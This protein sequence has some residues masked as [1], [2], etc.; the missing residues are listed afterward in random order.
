MNIRS[1]LSVVVVAV[2]VA[3]CSRT[4]VSV[5]VIS[6]AAENPFAGD[7]VLTMVGDNGDPITLNLGDLSVK[8][9]TT[10]LANPELTLKIEVAE[11]GTAQTVTLQPLADTSPRA[12]LTVTVTDD[13]FVF[14]W[15]NSADAVSA[16]LPRE[17]PVREA[18]ERAAAI[19][20]VTLEIVE[21]YIQ[22]LYGAVAG[23]DKDWKRAAGSLNASLSAYESRS[24]WIKWDKKI[25][26]YNYA[27]TNVSAGLERPIDVP[28]IGY[29]VDSA[30]VYGGMLYS[31]FHGALNSLS[32]RTP[33]TC[34]E[35][36]VKLRTDLEAALRAVRDL[37]K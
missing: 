27:F 20:E 31:C 34:I 16:T 22:Q 35:A 8:E 29:L 13:E 37:V 11:A 12:T 14:S 23:Y 19:A 30:E 33:S 1:I 7:L 36:R 24:I 18:R 9:H 6:Q 32:A 4:P 17:N 15:G 10:E 26:K 25:R 5:S 2:L 21:P 28:A 3:A